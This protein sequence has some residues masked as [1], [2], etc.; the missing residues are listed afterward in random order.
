MQSRQETTSKVSSTFI[1]L[2]EGF[3]Q[4]NN[5]LNKLQVGSVRQALQDYALIRTAIRRGQRDC[6]LEDSEKGWSQNREPF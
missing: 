5:D 3:Q 1:T 4:F 2:E 6:F